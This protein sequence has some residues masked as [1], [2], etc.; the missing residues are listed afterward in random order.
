M[1]ISASALLI[2][3]PLV[4]LA[5]FV[6]SIAGGGGLISLPA[7][8]VAGLP[9]HLAYGT[10][11]FAMSLGTMMSAG[12]YL[13]SGHVR[14]RP[15]LTAAA[16]ALA[17]S[18][19]GARLALLLEERYLHYCLIIIL[20]LV[21]AFL[22][23][24]RGFGSVARP[25][26]GPARLY[27]LC[28]FCGLVIGAYD[29]FFGP[30]TGTFLALAFTLLGFDLITASGNARVVNLAS[31]LAAVAAFGLGGSVL[32]WVALPAA[33]CAMAGSYLGVR[34]AVRRGAGF[35]RPMVA[36]VVALLFITVLWGFV[37][38]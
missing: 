36:G 6:D 14:L 34:L 25:Q 2:I 18:W 13:Q 5:G 22:L 4:F 19:A 23:F 29:G 21:A 33:G 8:L 26:P 7:Y 27:P 24:N 16:G 3:C 37:S 17:G 11:K 35:I 38:R 15:A 31:N 12:K 10:N 9:I 30:G 20:P 32:L 1:T 28:L